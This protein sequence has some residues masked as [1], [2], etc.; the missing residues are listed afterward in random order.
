M[1][2][3]GSCLIRLIQVPGTDHVIPR[4]FFSGRGIYCLYHALLLGFKTD[5]AGTILSKKYFAS[6]VV[7][8]QKLK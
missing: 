2:A 4:G 3:S 7:L 8:A 1:T 5:I 6:T